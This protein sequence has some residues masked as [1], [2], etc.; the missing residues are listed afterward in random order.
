MVCCHQGVVGSA[1]TVLHC[2]IAEMAIWVILNG[3]EPAA[4]AGSGRGGP[5]GAKMVKTA[6]IAMFLC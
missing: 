5:A 3:A 2:E 6:K 1:G 4:V